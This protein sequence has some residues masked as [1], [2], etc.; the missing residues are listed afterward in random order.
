[1]DA[2]NWARLGAP[3]TGHD[4]SIPAIEAGR[5]LSAESGIP[6]RFVQANVYDAAAVLD[7]TFDIVYTGI[8]ALNWLPDIRGWARVAAACLAKGGLL[9]LY[10]GH[11]LLWTLD[12]DR[13]D[14][15]LVVK[16]HHFEHQEPV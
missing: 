4:F 3:V 16:A 8:G 10:E 15:L 2:L 9:Y 6:G 13:A 14:D 12:Q 1:M 7:E 5:R 11:P